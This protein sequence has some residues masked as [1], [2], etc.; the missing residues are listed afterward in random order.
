MCNE[1]M[2]ATLGALS[3]SNRRRRAGVGMRAGSPD[4]HERSTRENPIAWE[5]RE[6][7]ALP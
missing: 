2:P 7:I 1:L 4:L 5:F 6:R 3:D